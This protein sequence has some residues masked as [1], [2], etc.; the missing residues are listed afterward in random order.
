MQSDAESAAPPEVTSV[1]VEVVTNWYEDNRKKN[2][3]VNTN[4]MTSALAVA[5]LLRDEFPLT[6][7]HVLS[8][9]GTQVHGLSG[10][11]VKRVLD[12]FDEHRSFTSE[13]GRTSR[14]TVGLAL[15]LRERLNDS[16]NE[17]A[18]GEGDRARVA[19][20]IQALVVERIQD[21]YFGKQGI[22]A[23]L[24]PDVTV[25]ANVSRILTEAQNHKDVSSGAVAQH[26]VG[27]KLELRFPNET[28]GR[29]SA[30][31]GDQQTRRQG[32]FQIG[33]TAFHVTM[34]P[35][36]KLED[37]A[38]SNIR[39]GYVPIILVPESK[40]Q[41]ARGLFDV[42]RLGDRV[43]V[44]SIET[45]VGTNIDEMGCFGIEETRRML[46]A[47]V[48]RYNERI[49][50]CEPDLSLRLR[51]PDWLVRLLASTDQERYCE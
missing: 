4:V 33:Q 44:Q 37:R 13:G 12:R 21:D 16:L 47:L 22:D 51:E 35:M 38:K 46:A 6:K 15:S 10:P 29:N 36:P 2:G 9:G 48:R 34:S 45:F 24:S 40:V 11:F 5:E 39:D 30:T 50:A 27:A 31:A 42:V 17:V 18:L 3:H 26:L 14:G 43:G 28:I 49:A 8:H 20:A 23:G 41:F 32:D 1:A 25:A 7:E 19:D